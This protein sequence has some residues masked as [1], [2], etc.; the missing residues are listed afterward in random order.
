MNLSTPSCFPMRPLRLPL[1][2]GS[3]QRG[4][5]RDHP[6]WCVL[7]IS[8]VV[9]ISLTI[10]IGPASKSV[11]A[12]R[13]ISVPLPSIWHICHEALVSTMVPLHPPPLCRNP[14]HNLSMSFETKLTHHS[15]SSAQSPD[16]EQGE[17]QDDS[18]TIWK[19]FLTLNVSS[20]Q[21]NSRTTTP[22]AKTQFPYKAG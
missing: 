4:I 15:S 13:K 12:T 2:P 9:V 11:R 19:T 14:Q 1:Y 21:G 3:E 7:V 20:L 22:H 18:G 16:W 17:D 6:E 10:T 8:K 5:S